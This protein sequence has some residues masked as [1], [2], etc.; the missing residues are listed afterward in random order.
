VLGHVQRGGSPVPYDRVLATRLGTAAAELAAAGRWGRMVCLR[1][2]EIADVPIA[3]AVA[4]KKYVDP[5]GDLVACARATG[6]SFG[7]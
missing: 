4:R 7:E 5:A 2:E 6:I 3:E 1:G